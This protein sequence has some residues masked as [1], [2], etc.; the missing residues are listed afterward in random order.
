MNNA[1]K[2]FIVSTLFLSVATGFVTWHGKDLAKLEKAYTLTEV[3]SFC[4]R[5]VF[6]GNITPTEHGD[7]LVAG[8][9]LVG[10]RQARAY[11]LLIQSEVD[12]NFARVRVERRE[13]DRLSEEAAGD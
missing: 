12:Q 1:T 9:R 10:R 7:C 2:L 8:I 6:T 11:T 5:A 3:T 4:I 13:I